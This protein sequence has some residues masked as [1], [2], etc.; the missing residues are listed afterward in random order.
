MTITDITTEKIPII[1]ITN[2]FSVFF[3]I[4]LLNIEKL[5]SIDQKKVHNYCTNNYYY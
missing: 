4:P 3:S 5:R 1:P 2:I